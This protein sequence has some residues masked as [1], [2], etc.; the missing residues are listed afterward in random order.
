MGHQQPDAS[1]SAVAAL[2][3]SNA[4]LKAASL[5][6][7]IRSLLCEPR[8][9]PAKSAVERPAVNGQAVLKMN[10]KRPKN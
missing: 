7:D 2:A 8:K 9:G 4:H 1:R 5:S 10:T 3:E 6:S